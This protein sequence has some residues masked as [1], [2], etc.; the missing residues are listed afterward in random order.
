MAEVAHIF[1][2]DTF[3]FGTPGQGKNLGNLFGRNQK[4]RLPFIDVAL[5][6]VPPFVSISHHEFAARIFA[7]C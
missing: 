3:S 2:L 6:T 5:E 4:L 1:I 7:F